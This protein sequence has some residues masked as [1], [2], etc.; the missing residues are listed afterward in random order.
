MDDQG[1]GRSTGAPWDSSAIAAD[2]VGATQR[3][4]AARRRRRQ[5]VAGLWVLGVAVVA[6]GVITVALSV[7]RSGT[8]QRAA[9]SSEGAAASSSTSS[10][11]TPPPGAPVITS[12]TPAQASVGQTVVIAGSNLVS[13]DGQVLAHFG[14]VT[15]PT[16]CQSASSCTA[17]VPSPSGP[18]PRVPVTVS[19]QAGTSNPLT[20][21]YA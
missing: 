7:H 12:L 17:T 4:L 20:F 18:T 19:T 2:P 21:T 16:S 6:L 9:G 11:S 15:A 3:T 10:T 1:W 13:A 8:G 14:G 5:W